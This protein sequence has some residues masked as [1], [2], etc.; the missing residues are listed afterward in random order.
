MTDLKII[1]LRQR[2]KRQQRQHSDMQAAAKRQQHGQTKAQKTLKKAQ[3][4]LQY[5]NLDAHFLE[6]R[7]ES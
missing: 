7:D 1:N 4:Q 6:P 3:G 2:R 5:K